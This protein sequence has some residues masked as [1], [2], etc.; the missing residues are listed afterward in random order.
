MSSPAREALALAACYVLGS[1]SF[2]VLLVRLFRGVDVREHGSGNAGA[3]NVLRT[4]GKRLGVATLFLDAA[5]GALAVFLMRAVTYDPRWL[6]A[7]AVAAVVGHMF[8]VFFGFKGGKGVAT[9]V[10]AYLVLTPLG[11]LSVM[12]V[13]FLVVGTTRIVSLGSITAACLMPL[14]LRLLFHSP[15]ATVAAAACLTILLVVSHR[16]NVRRLLAGTEHRIGE[17]KEPDE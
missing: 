3:T 13:F 10:G 17:E 11:V 4:A 16:A 2:A 12:V 5:K 8:P 9:A 7:A 14:V 15:D 1:I 6:G